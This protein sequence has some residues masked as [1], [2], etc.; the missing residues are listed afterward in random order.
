[1]KFGE[2]VQ[3][4][5]QLKDPSKEVMVSKG[6]KTIVIDK[7]K[8]KEYLSKGWGLAE[9]ASDC[10]HTCPKSCPDCG[11]TGNPK[12]LGKKVQEGKKKKPDAD[13]DGVPD[14]ADKKPGKDDNAGKKK[15]SKPKKGQ[16]PPQFQKKESYKSQISNRLAE[17]LKKNK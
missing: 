17:Q 3:E 1:M 6:G 14:W 4:T 12:K 5:R 11:G 8:E 15:G 7:S 13:G 2:E 16:V 10:D 9:S